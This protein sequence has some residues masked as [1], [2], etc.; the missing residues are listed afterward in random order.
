M[1]RRPHALDISCSYSISGKK[2]KKKLG[3]SKLEGHIL[4]KDGK[5]IIRLPMRSFVKQFLDKLWAILTGDNTAEVSAL[6]TASIA[7]GAS[8]ARKAGIM[9][10]NGL[11]IPGITSTNLS[12]L[13]SSVSYGC[14]YGGHSFLAPYAPSDTLLKTTI[15][16]L[17]TNASSANWI[18]REV[19]L[20]VKK[21]ASTASNVGTK[22]MT[23]D[24]VTET[25][26]AASDKLVSLEFTVGR[27]SENG[28][29]VL[30]LLRVLYNL[31]LHGNANYSTFLPRIGSVTISHANA[32][33]TSHL[34]VDGVAAKYWGVVVGVPLDPDSPGEEELE[35]FSPSGGTSG[36][37][38]IPPDDYRFA[39]N[40]DLTYGANTI[41]A[42]TISGRKAYFT[43]SRD[44]TNGSTVAIIINRIGLLTKGA[45]AAPS[46][47]QDDQI[48]L[49]INRSA[50]DI[51]LA[52]N[53]TIRVEY[54][55]EI[56]A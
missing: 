30:N 9:V 11:S 52:P 17:I 2:T 46:T 32:S 37:P 36:N 43:I 4:I 24:A 51:S 23:L 35:G 1:D 50:D 8:I 47:L 39:I 29:A 21:T 20:K 34:V 12:G 44:I 42:V 15:T 19:G 55:M 25:F 26:Y 27:T 16:R 3:K 7:V 13:V 5:S 31:Y 38:V 18:I 10:G 41:S 22:L 56:E 49:M 6:S 14:T 33:A 40:T 53:Q 28:G 48:F 54:K 45:T